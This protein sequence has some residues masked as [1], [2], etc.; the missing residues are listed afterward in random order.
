MKA[1]WAFAAA[2]FGALLVQGT[3]SA[4]HSFAAEFDRNQ[5]ITDHGQRHE[6]RVGEPARALLRRR[7]GRRGPA[8][9]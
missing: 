2:A 1:Y 9:S 5:K 3:V 7:E 4:H 6:G 8:R